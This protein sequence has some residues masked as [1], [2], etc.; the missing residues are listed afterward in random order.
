MRYL[1]RYSTFVFL[2]ILLLLPIV[3]VLLQ[4][5]IRFEFEYAPY[6]QVETAWHCE[7]LNFYFQVDEYGCSTGTVVVENE[8]YPVELC[9][10]PTMVHLYIELDEEYD[11]MVTAKFYSTKDECV[12]Y[13]ISD[14]PIIGR[15][16]VKF[17]KVVALS[18]EDNFVT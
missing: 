8:S 2:V 11:E 5:Y 14:N 15:N 9:F 18:Q 1:R 17:K 4:F 6:K 7:E 16:T 13:S 12:L 3:F 10:M